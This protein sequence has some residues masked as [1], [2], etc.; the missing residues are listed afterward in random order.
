MIKY[1]CGDLFKPVK[2][3][4]ETHTVIIP[5]CVNDR[6]AFSSGFVLPLGKQFPEAKDAYY[7]WKAAYA[8]QYPTL[9]N[10]F[11]PFALGETLFV[12][13]APQIIVAHMC[14]QTLGGVR[15]LY[16]NALVK[17][18]DA[19]G[20]YAEENKAKIIA[21]AFGSNLA[22]GDF[23]FIEQLIQ[24]CWMRDKDLDVTIYYLKGTLPE[25]ESRI[26]S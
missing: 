12:P 14:A 8:G 17:C 23:K 9:V 22:G 24:D 13:V 5:H 19:V 20:K 10:E 3:I 21:P 1:V 4:A 15:P 7:L 16:Y 18:M 25:V 2:A 6:G 11:P 26:Q